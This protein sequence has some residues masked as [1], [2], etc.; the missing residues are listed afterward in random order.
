MGCWPANG[1]SNVNATSMIEQDAAA[2]VEEGTSSAKVDVE[3]KIEQFKEEET[4]AEDLI[5]KHQNFPLLDKISKDHMAF[6]WKDGMNGQA[7]FESKYGKCHC[8]VHYKSRGDNDIH[9]KGNRSTDRI[10]MFNGVLKRE[11]GAKTVKCFEDFCRETHA[12]I[13]HIFG[14]GCPAV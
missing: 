9:C 6:G 7:E 11:G 12:A 1:A 14:S 4:L 8:T 10:G 3:R 13:Q 5:S 2:L